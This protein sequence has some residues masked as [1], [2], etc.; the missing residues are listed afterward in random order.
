MNGSST[1]KAVE[2]GGGRSVY[3]CWQCTKRLNVDD[4]RGSV[5]VICPNSKCKAK[6]QLRS[7]LV[8]N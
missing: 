8:A 2:E 7:S 4:V 3:R 1:G 6:N 5:T